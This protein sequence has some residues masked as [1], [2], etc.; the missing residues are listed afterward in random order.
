MSNQ[1]WHL[2]RSVPLSMIFAIACQTVALIW[3]VATLRNDV[4]ANQSKIIQL[5]TRTEALSGMVQDQSVMIARMDEN[6]KAIRDL[7]ERMAR[8]Q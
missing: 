2:S 5:E 1:E 3:F 8:H 4:D 6:I 7:I